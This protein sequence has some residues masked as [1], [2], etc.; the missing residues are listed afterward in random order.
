[1]EAL[2]RSEVWGLLTPVTFEPGTLVIRA[3]EPAE[4]FLVIIYGAADILEP[5]TGEV[6][7]AVGQGSILGELALLSSGRRSHDVVATATI[8]GWVGDTRA[9]DRALQVDAFRTHVGATA[10]KRLAAFARTV[11]TLDRLGHEIAVRPLLPT[12]RHQYLAAVTSASRETLVNRFFS[13]APP[14]Q[15]VIDY[16]LDVDYLRHFAWVALDLSVPGTAGEG[17][18]VGRYIRDRQ[19]PGTAELAIAVAEPHRRRGIA[20]L[21]LGALGVTA[22]A[23]GISTLTANVLADNHPMRALLEGMGATWERA[24]PGVLATSLRPERLATLFDERAA[25]QLRSSIEEMTRAATL[26]LS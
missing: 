23:S 17:A 2:R 26:A 24:E 11:S 15:G 9:F 6:L 7:A 20:S 13:G 12:D 19:D 10:A 18:G 22:A 14:S 21:L 8:E 5:S 16:L 25:D 3:G 4:H 1:V